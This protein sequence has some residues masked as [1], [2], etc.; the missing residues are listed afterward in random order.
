VFSVKPQS[1]PVRVLLYYV[2]YLHFDY[3]YDYV[4]DSIDVLDILI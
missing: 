4:N 1:A 3:D 2:L